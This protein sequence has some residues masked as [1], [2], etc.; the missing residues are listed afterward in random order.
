M[1]IVFITGGIFLALQSSVQAQTAGQKT[2]DDAALQAQTLEGQISR[3]LDRHREQLQVE[4][5]SRQSAGKGRSLTSGEIK[6]LRGLFED[7]I[8][9]TEVRIYQ[10]KW[11]FFQSEDT[12]MSPNGN[13]YYPPANPAYSDDF[14]E[15]YD[16][17]AAS[18]YAS[19]V[20]RNVWLFIHEM[21]HV[22][23]YHQ[24][25][26]LKTRRVLE[27]G[28]CDYLSAFKPGKDLTQYAV[29]QQADFIANYFECLWVSSSP[30]F[31]RDSYGETL[32]RFPAIP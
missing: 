15:F 30:Q 9:Y 29:E 24:G 11:M 2:W 12:I 8:P 32:G 13:I 16:S 19:E 7:T 5:G 4:K 20:V 18:G 23:Q 17:L 14:S 21:A 25:T 28:S 26:V 10:S 3:T 6:M 31:C 1:K 27:G 22:Y